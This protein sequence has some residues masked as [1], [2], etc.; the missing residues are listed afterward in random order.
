MSVSTSSEFVPKLHK[1]SKQLIMTRRFSLSAP[2]KAGIAPCFTASVSCMTRHQFHHWPSLV[3]AC[4]LSF[5]CFHMLSASSNFCKAQTSA[6]K[7]L[8]PPPLIS[9]YSAKITTYWFHS[10]H[11]KA[12]CRI[13]ADITPWARLA[14]LPDPPGNKRLACLNNWPGRVAI[15]RF[16]KNWSNPSILSPLPTCR[17]RSWEGR[18]SSCNPQWLFQSDSWTILRGWMASPLFLSRNQVWNKLRHEFYQVLMYLLCPPCVLGKLV[19]HLLFDV[20]SQLSSR[21]GLATEKHTILHLLH[22]SFLTN[23]CSKTKL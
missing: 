12:G 16:L 3:T 8:R 11:H 5:S 15:G 23:F 7:A 17:S 2:K 9:S 18:L 1:T 14:L 13:T 10:W 20:F 4:H 19:H 6:R 21:L 22:P